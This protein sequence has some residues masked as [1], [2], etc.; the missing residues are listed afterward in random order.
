MRTLWEWNKRKI[1]KHIIKVIFNESYNTITQSTVTRK[2]VLI[3]YDL[4]LDFFAESWVMFI[5]NTHLDHIFTHCALFKLF[6]SLL[7]ASTILFNPLIC[8][9]VFG[10]FWIKP[11]YS[12]FSE[13]D[14][15][16]VFC[17]NNYVNFL[18]LIFFDSLN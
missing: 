4:I 18:I 16:L 3:L 11:F 13:V 6:L 12:F 15:I 17:Y 5:P 9:F 7:V 14:V 2:S 8:F 1:K 10:I